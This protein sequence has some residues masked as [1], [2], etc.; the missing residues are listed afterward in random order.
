VYDAQGRLLTTTSPGGRVTTSTFSPNGRMVSSTAPD[1]GITAYTYDAAGKVLTVT[2]PTGAVT[3][4][5]YNTAGQLATTTDP[6]GAV[7]TF[8]YDINGR[9]VATIAP[10]NVRTETGYD[11]LA[12]ATSSTTPLGDQRLTSFDVEG[13]PTTQTVASTGAASVTEYDADGRVT[14]SIDPDGRRSE[15]SYDPNGRLVS[16]LAAGGAQSVYGFD[17]LGRR[18]TVTDARGGITTTT[19]TP[20][21]RTA[22]VTDP[23]G[24]VTSYTY[25]VAGRTAV[26]T[27]PGG[28]E[29][30][31]VYNPDGQAVSES[32]PSGLATTYTYDP[33]GRVATMT[34]PAGVVTA[35]T[36]NL[37]GDMLTEKIGA[38]GVSSNV[39]NPTGTL[40][41]V[42]DPLGNTTS[43]TYDGRGNTLT[44]TDPL[45]G[46]E[47]WT[48]NNANQV[49]SA[50]DPLGR[51]TTATYNDAGQLV[52]T[53]DPSGRTSTSTYNFDGSIASSVVTDGTT[54]IPTVYTYDDAGRVASVSE[55]DGAAFSSYQYNVAGDLI[56]EGAITYGYDVAGRRTSM[57]YTD[58][59]RVNYQYNAA[60]QL[61]KIV[62]NEEMVDAFGLADGAAP[63]ATNWTRTAAAGTSATIDQERLLFAVSDTATGAATALLTSKVA[64]RLDSDVTFDYQWNS[65]FPSTK[66]VAYARYSTAGH[67]RIEMAANTPTAT[68]FKR[69]GVVNTTLGTVPLPDNVGQQGRVQMRVVGDT[70]TVTITDT[71]S[72]DGAANTV[73]FTS[74]GV[75]AAGTSRLGLTRVLGGGQVWINDWVQADPTTPTVVAGYTYNPDGQLLVETLPGGNRT[76]TYTNGRMVGFNETVPGRTVATT[77]AYDTTGRIV[78]DTTGTLTTNYTYDAASQLLSATPTTGSASTWTYD[79]LGRRRT[80]K[81]AATTTKYVYDAGS[82]LC[83]ST[84]G[85]LAANATCNTAPASAAKF[86]WDP[87]GR[88]LSETRTATNKVNY[89]YD[90]MGRMVNA[91]RLSGTTTTNQTRTYRTDGLI[92]SLATQTV[93]A[94]ATTNTNAFLDWDL[95]AGGVPQLV[96]VTNLTAA[97]YTQINLVYGPGGFAAIHT[98]A[99]QP[100]AVAQDAH[101]SIIP[102]TGN[103]LARA[104]VYSAHGTPTGTNTFDIRLGYRGELTIDSQVNLRARSYQSTIGMMTTRDPAP[105]RPGTTTLVNPYHYADNNPLNR[106]D[107]TGRTSQGETGGSPVGQQTAV[108]AE[109]KGGGFGV[110]PGAS[111]TCGGDIG[112]GCTITLTDQ[113]G[114]I[115][116]LGEPPDVPGLGRSIGACGTGSTSA[117]VHFEASVCTVATGDGNAILLTGGFGTGA[118]LAGGFGIDGVFS[119][120]KSVSDWEGFAI[121]GGGSAALRI[122]IEGALCFSISGFSNGTEFTGIWSFFAGVAFGFGSEGHLAVTHTW[123]PIEIPSYQCTR[124][125]SIVAP[126]LAAATC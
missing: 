91:T 117:I 53:L 28:R 16:T 124:I 36:Y 40:A 59:R 57:Q 69:V 118:G 66:L 32:T 13:R 78:T 90:V 9:R 25:D 77:L 8:E 123:S 122:G 83:W 18:T 87:A 43:Y 103:T 35:R 11:E 34:A 106:T 37:R 64:A 41:S 39:Y 3:T 105:G 17:L 81:I 21:G 22:T 15:N 73:S 96:N 54:T 100:V 113:S 62:R 88:L 58:D 1:G 99:L 56:A 108:G 6:A 19:F 72:P 48:Y 52:S 31:T 46:V 63:S 60:G 94:T 82:Q 109:S 67:Y 119:N 125:G 51:V 102:S 80:E 121:C 12:R 38:Q 115:T 61:S 2:D 112:P 50:T 10:G 76:R 89:G 24:L 20:G 120:A 85:T 33:A 79:Q 29:L 42:T 95:A 75:S 68:I 55:N 74:G 47:S 49:L 97:G 110:S 93:T 84:T 30:A 107:P 70:I 5:A 126:L 14:A 92:G 104:A 101:G 44:R 27:L 98:A 116:S 65:F 4:S 7:T 23:A 111:S 114:R 86:A 26:V 71:E 45:G